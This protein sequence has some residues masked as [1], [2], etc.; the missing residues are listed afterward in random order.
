MRTTI[1]CIPCFIDHGVHISKM[2]ASDEAM[3]RVLVDAVLQEMLKHGLDDPPPLMARRIN[4]V[5]RDVAGVRDPYMEMKDR[6]TAFA[7]E[8]LPLVL[9]DLEAHADR[10]EA[11]LRLAIAGNII[12]YG[13]DK[14]FKLEDAHGKILEAFNEPLDLKATGLLKRAMDSAKRILYIA[15]NCGEAVFDRIF[16]E[17]YKEKI[18]LAVRGE[19]ILNDITRREV[20]GSGLLDFAAEIVDTGDFTPGVSLAHSGAEFIE[21]YESADLI[22]AKGQ[23]NYETLSDSKRPIFFL[24]RAKCK[25]VAAELGG[26]A[27]GS[28]QV[29]PANIDVK[30]LS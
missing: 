6:S 17:P 7:L 2:V 30:R 13:V 14:N 15:D 23:G 27:L 25:V 26:V 9:N 22:V 5:I 12:D 29:I 11:A 20:S 21:T 24:F 3:R 10:F 1:D 18:T 19:P 28:F 16:I 8:L 4:S